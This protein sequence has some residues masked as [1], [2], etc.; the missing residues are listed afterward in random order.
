MSGHGDVGSQ[1][2]LEDDQAEQPTFQQLSDNLSKE[3]L[4]Q[5]AVSFH[6]L[7]PPARLSLGDLEETEEIQRGD[8]CL[9]QV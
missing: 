1:V 6:T 3:E 4:S 2:N 7:K 9:L 5:H 8:T